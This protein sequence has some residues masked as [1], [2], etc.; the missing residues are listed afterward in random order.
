[1]K[2]RFY[3]LVLG[4][5][6][7][8]GV[9][10]SMGVKEPFQE[11][12][13][14]EDPFNLIYTVDFENA[15]VLDF[16]IDKIPKAIPSDRR[17]EEIELPVTQSPDKVDPLLAKWLRERPGNVREL[18]IITFQDDLKIP[19]FPEA[20]EDEPRDSKANK[21][22]LY[23]SKKLVQEI[24]ERRA[25]DYMTL[26]KELRKE[27]EAKVIRTYWLIKG[28]VAE[29][30]LDSVPELVKRDDVV[31][32]AP[33]HS[34]DDPPDAN[35]NNDVEDARTLLKSDVYANNGFGEVGWIG[36]LDTGVRF[37]HTLFQSLSQANIGIKGDCVKGSGTFPQDDCLSPYGE[38]FNPEDE[39]DHGTSSAAILVGNNNLGNAYKGLTQGAVDSWKVYDPDCMLDDDAA[40][41][42]FQAAV[43]FLDRVIVAEMQSSQTPHG[44]ISDAANKAFD[45]GMV[46]IAANGNFGPNSG[47][48]KAPANTTKVLGVGA[49]N[50][51]TG[52][53][54]S[55]QSRGPAPDPFNPPPPQNIMDLFR[56]KPDIQ[57]PTDTET[58]G[59]LSD[60]D[61]HAF[62]G[63]SG[64]TPYAG[65]EA[66]LWRNWLK[67]GVGLTD[68]GYTYAM[69][70]LSGPLT[71][72]DFNNEMGVGHLR[73]PV[74]GIAFLSK[75]SVPEGM[76]VVVDLDLTEFQP[77]RTGRLEVAIWWDEATSIA[78]IPV[79]HRDID[80]RVL[81][82]NGNERA[83]SKSIGSVF[84]REGVNILEP[85]SKPGIWKVE[86]LGHDCNI[87][88]T[89]ESGPTPP[90]RVY[91]AAA[92]L[93]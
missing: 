73:M 48:V 72:P 37:S 51:E 46:V 80:L 93:E 70:I 27:F 40:L 2:S 83:K 60:T 42:G 7:T 52:Q 92:A 69:M 89:C 19:R 62:G 81:D 57:M 41:L 68:P 65:G 32:I 18:L 67:K 87:F 71:Y 56:I 6:L 31:Y 55:F 64:A 14:P 63:T 43:S 53:T 10:A 39:C 91:F 85:D 8:S 49:F 33:K 76:K 26:T 47:T 20:V 24:K 28:I 5:L 21:E 61:L 16:S 3:G 29:M 17:K 86:V 45:A 13:E 25:D 4:I 35:P 1:M 66:A 9:I 15:K 59:N 75:L 36:L 84:E 79:H 34:E 30:R 82:P 78:G 54:D 88:K 38:L 44:D 23:R 74:N 12:G 22:A 58:A 77:S 11:F 50:V 90:Q